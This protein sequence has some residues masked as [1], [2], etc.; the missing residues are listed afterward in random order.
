MQSIDNLLSRLDR[1]K[2]TGNQRW[3]A[4]CPAHGD[5]NPSLSLRETTDGR[6]LLHCFSG[7]IPSEILDSIGLK[8]GDLF[9]DNQIAT[10]Q[11][12][13]PSREAIEWSYAINL[14]ADYDQRQGVSH[15]DEDLQAIVRAADILGEIPMPP[16]PNGKRKLAPFSKVLA[17]RQ[18]Y[19]NRPFLVVVCVGIDAWARAKDWANSEND[20]VGLML[21]DCWPESYIWPVVRCVVMIEKI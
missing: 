20:I 17:D 8:L 18:R 7:C 3:M 2:S 14:I 21:P 10:W 19:D 5:K 4:R 13:G 6:I 15:S 11:A 1:V 9:N 12:S 16:K